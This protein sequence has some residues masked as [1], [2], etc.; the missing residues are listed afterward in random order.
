M[1]RMSRVVKTVAAISALGLVLAACGGSGDKGSSGEPDP[2]NLNLKKDD[3][4]AAMVPA[5]LAAK[6]K[7]IIATDASYA[8]NEFLK[9]GE[10]EPIGMSIDLGN[11]LAQLMGLETEWTNVDFDGILAG[12]NAGRYDISISSFTDTKKREE[13]VNFVSYLEA[14]TSI[15]VAAGNP[16]NVSKAE[17]LC[18]LRVGAENGTTQ[19]DMLT[20]DDVDDSIV[21]IC[22]DAGKDPVQFTGLPTQ[23]D[24][25]SA[26]ISD[27]L[28]AYMADTPVAEYAVKVTGDEFEK[29]G[30]DVGVAPYGVAVP[31]EPAE[32]TDVVQAA[33]QKL[34]DDGDYGKILENWGLEDAGISK[35]E[36]NIAVF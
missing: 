34:M 18:G 17:D 35:A 28:D 16:K 1:S 31:K 30:S 22:A 24:V 33:M 19:E 32:L 29:V 21:K 8:P 13:E 5:D 36:V 20:L 23:N 27:R 14:G 2:L 26:L 3:A 12:L 4:I 11:A 10:G 9:G 25:N 7:L 15:V 6:G